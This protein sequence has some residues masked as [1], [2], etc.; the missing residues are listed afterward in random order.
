MYDFAVSVL[1]KVFNFLALYHALKISFY[2]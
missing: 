1:A 2:I